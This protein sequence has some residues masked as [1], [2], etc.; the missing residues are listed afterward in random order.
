MENTGQTWSKDNTTVTF[1]HSFSYEG[2]PAD[3]EQVTTY[4]YPFISVYYQ[5]THL[6]SWLS[7]WQALAQMS[8]KMYNQNFQQAYYGM[9]SYNS[10][11]WN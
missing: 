8:Y 2:L 7:K 6:P 5:M 1:G 4:N 3:T 11:F 10:Y 9:N